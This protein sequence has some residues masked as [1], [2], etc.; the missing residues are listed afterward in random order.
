MIGRYATKIVVG[1]DR[2]NIGSAPT[3][4]VVPPVLEKVEGSGA[5]IHN[6]VVSVIYYFMMINV[7]TIFYK[8]VEVPGLVVS[9]SKIIKNSKFAH[10]NFHDGRLGQVK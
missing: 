7:L 2:Y 3:I 1:A 5:V 6:L 10:G 8:K 4:E 9:F